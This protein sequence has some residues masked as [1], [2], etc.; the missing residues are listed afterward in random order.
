MPYDDWKRWRQHGIGGSDVAT[1]CGLNKYKSAF[2]LWAEKTGRYD[3]EIESS[4]SAYW[5]HQLE[6]VI[7][8]EFTKRTGLTVMLEQNLLQHEKYPW[9]LANLDG[10]VQS[11]D[12]KYIFEAKTAGA[13]RLQEWDQ[14][15]VPYPYQLQVQHYMAVTGF[16]GTYVAVLIGGQE[17]RINY[18]GRDDEIINMLIKLE[19]QFWQYVENNI[20]P[21]V[22][23]S[24]AAK[25]FV[26]SRYPSSIAKKSIIL[27][28]AYI[29][30]VDDYERYQEQ[31]KEIAKL[32]DKAANQLK[33]FIGDCEIATAEL[34]K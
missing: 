23:G 10:I 15:Y 8:A 25:D 27:D 7:C 26:N 9:M 22:D 4:E 33:E 17:F 24:E 14:N 1:I 5:G 32:K 34:R 3:D 31:E 18:I 21:P 13:Y 11:A 2:Q 12:A 29:S 28:D 16:V 30:L 6:P 20:P 19:S